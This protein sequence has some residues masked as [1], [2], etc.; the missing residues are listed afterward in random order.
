MI[1]WGLLLCALCAL[2]WGGPAQARKVAL[3]IGNSAY[4]NTSALAN[5]GNDA[6]LVARAARE[7][8]F[9]VVETANLGSVGFRDAL[10]NFRQAV[11]GA[12]VAMIYYAGHAI[13]GQGKNWLIPVDAK[14]ETEFDLPYEAIDF[15]R[16]LES[17]S[18]SRMR[19]I[20]LDACRNNPFGNTWKRGYRSVPS[21]LAGMEVDDVLVLYAAAPGQLATDGNT[22]A[23]NSPFALS[24]AKRLPE[25]GLAVQLLGGVVRDDVLAATGGKQ[26]P[27]VSASITGTPIY[28]KAAPTSLAATG[29][30]PATGGDRSRIEAL[31]WQGAASADSK[32][33][34]QAYLDEFPNGIFA[35]MAREKLT[36]PAARL[37]ATGAP[38]QALAREAAAA[39]PMNDAPVPPKLV[40]P[41]LAAATPGAGVKVQE[42]VAMVVTNP[43]AA[44][45]VPPSNAPRVVVKETLV[46]PDSGPR[47]SAGDKVPGVGAGS[48]AGPQ[49]AAIRT[50]SP[51]VSDLTPLPAMPLTPAFPAEA[52]PDCRESHKAAV[53]MVAQVEAINRCTV[54]LD[55]YYDTALGGFSRAM[56]AHQDALTRL[57]T[58]RVGGMAQY[59]QASQDRFYRAMIKEHSDA[60]PDGAHFAPYRTAEARYKQDREFLKQQYCT[61]AGCPK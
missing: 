12:D 15:D 34:Y 39:K 7:A 60:N 25:P 16:L 4:V 14:L 50:S 44:S 59:S 57:Y 32:A 42:P 54:L 30:A 51:P 3:V 40:A 18:G 48:G 31:M 61:A 23:A 5:P 58:D 6:T 9:D 21:G 36:L 35:K 47:V 27:F 1:R 19:M 13:E 53:G 24:L 43:P 45:A 46:A 52:Y 41:R 17:L 38:M 26:R 49:V 28:L 11:D 37:A 22:G 29:T 33:G 55:K 56:G 10:R 8:G 20:V 2:V